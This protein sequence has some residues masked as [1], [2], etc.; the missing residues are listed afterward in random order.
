MNEGWR[1]EA[2]K[3]IKNLSEN[4]VASMGGELDL[5]IDVGYPT[6]FNHETLTNIAAEKAGEYVGA[7]NVSETEVRMGAEDF[8]FYTQV[9]PGCFYRLGVQQKNET[10][11][12]VHTPVFD[13]D[14]NAI[15]L[16]MGMMAWLGASVE[17]F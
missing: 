16:G 12:N 10:V 15:E 3:L 6:V 7:E 9:I 5:L 17:K 2:H 4:L 11:R 8:G 1:F 14:E 13:V